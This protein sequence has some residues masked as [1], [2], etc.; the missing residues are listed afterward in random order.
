[1][2]LYELVFCLSQIHRLGMHVIQ[3]SE[4]T[5]A[6]V[7]RDQRFHVSGASSIYHL[8]EAPSDALYLLNPI[9]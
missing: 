8:I 1:M 5:R 2:L 3:A 7:A 9:G 6:Q 4:A